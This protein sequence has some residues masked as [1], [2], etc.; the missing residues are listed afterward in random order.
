MKEQSI[1]RTPTRQT[2]YRVLANYCH[3]YLVSFRGWEVPWGMK[4]HEMHSLTTLP[5]ALKLSSRD[6][7]NVI[8]LL[9]T[10]MININP[11][12]IQ[13]VAKFKH[14]WG[15]LVPAEDRQYF[16]PSIKTLTLSHWKPGIV[17]TFIHP[18]P[19]ERYLSLFLRLQT[20]VCTYFRQ[21]TLNLY[22]ESEHKP[23]SELLNTCHGLKNQGQST[24]I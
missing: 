9:S 12:N 23:C 20:K 7:K 14:Q 15:S 17:V 10:Q 16:F 3:M 1:W 24:K 8:N 19:V 6:L 5:H 18:H 22:A 13:S 4:L 11:L 21:I 2:R